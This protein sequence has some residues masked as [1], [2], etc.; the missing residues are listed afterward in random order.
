[1]PDCPNHVS[2]IRVVTKDTKWEMQEVWKYG[3]T[4][5][6]FM[7]YLGDHAKGQVAGKAS[8]DT[9]WRKLNLQFFAEDTGIKAKGQIGNN[10]F[11]GKCNKDN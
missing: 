5:R 6:S 3:G 7:D 9:P 11:F 8:E 10:T 1:M 2:N 4:D